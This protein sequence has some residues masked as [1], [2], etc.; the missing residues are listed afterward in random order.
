MKTSILTGLVFSY[1]Q[2]V[3]QLSGSIEDWRN[4]LMQDRQPFS[5]S[6]K[7]QYREDYRLEMRYNYESERTVALY[8]GRLFRKEK[9]ADF[10]IMPFAGQL[11]GKSRGFSAGFQGNLVL[12]NFYVDGDS[13]FTCFTSNTDQ[14]FFLSW[15]EVGREINNG[16]TLGCL[17]Q[18][19]AL[20]AL[21]KGTVMWGLS[22][23]YCLN[24]WV[25]SIYGLF[26]TFRESNVACR[27]VWNWGKSSN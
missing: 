1:L 14:S 6:L 5:P 2:L 24:N 16:L 23:E 26:K 13:Q 10:R 8:A 20:Q 27:I 18:H 21:R 3:A 22:S 19:T 17:T 12:R 4:Y 25:I 11:F 9:Q 7:I 15:L